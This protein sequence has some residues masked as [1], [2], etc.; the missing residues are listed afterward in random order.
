M[1]MD[2]SLPSVG[3]IGSYRPHSYY[4]REDAPKHEPAV[5][6]KADLPD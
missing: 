5:V 6:R 4:W 1:K 3:E 2:L